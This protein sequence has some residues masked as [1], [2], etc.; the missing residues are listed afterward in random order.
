MHALRLIAPITDEQLGEVTDLLVA[1]ARERQH[2]INADHPL[3]QEFW[4]AFDYL[5]G[6]P[7][8]TASGLDTRPRLNHA[9]DAELIAVNLN[10]YVE[11]AA[12]HRQQI[13]V[14]SELKKVLRTSKTR[15]YI[16]TKTVKSGVKVGTDGYGKAVYC[17]VFERPGRR[18]Y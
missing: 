8:H 16:D 3:V 18:Q 12:L 15:R 2:S 5:D 11:L 1:M 4:E 6:L 9:I 10:E 13:P 14:L 7:Q 17:W